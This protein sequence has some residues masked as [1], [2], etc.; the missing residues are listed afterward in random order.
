MSE[1]NIIHL[2]NLINFTVK[3]KIFQMSKNETELDIY[4]DKLCKIKY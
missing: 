3:T 2:K 1:I 4:Q